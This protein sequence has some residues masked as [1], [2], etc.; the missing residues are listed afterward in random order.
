VPGIGVEIVNGHGSRRIIR[1][2]PM[3]GFPRVEKV[4]SSPGE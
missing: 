3:T 1:L 2:D 4:A